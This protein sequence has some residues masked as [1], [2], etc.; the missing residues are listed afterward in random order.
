M[1]RLTQEEF[2]ARAI[3]IHGDKYD[4]SKSLYVNSRTDVLI[5][6]N[7]CGKIFPQ[8][9]QS[10]LTGKGCRA[11]AMKDVGIKNTG[12]P[13]YKAKHIVLGVGINDL[14][15]CA[16]GNKCYEIWHSVL[17]R[18]VDKE[19]KSSHKAFVAFLPSLSKSVVFRPF[20]DSA[21]FGADVGVSLKIG[22][23]PCDLSNNFGSSGYSRTFN[24]IKPSSTRTGRQ[25]TTARTSSKA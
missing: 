6:C 24:S 14:N 10:H 16:L 5:R 20:S 21:I 23:V 12:K 18:T 22:A 15:V 19:Y 4:Y 7:R 25:R 17:Q 1:K 13:N 11:C 8:N 9:P 2:I 3:A